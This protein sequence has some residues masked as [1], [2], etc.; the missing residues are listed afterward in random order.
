MTEADR[1]GLNVVSVK[2]FTDD[3][4]SDFTS[5]LNEIKAAGADLV[6]LPIYYSPASLILA[7][8]DR[9]R[10]EPKFFGVDGLDGIL[11]IENFDISL[12]EGVMLLTPF[13]ADSEDELTQSF[14]AKYREKYSETPNQ[15]A[16]DGYDAV[17]AIY[18][19]CLNKNITP[20]M[21]PQDICDALVE[22]FTNPEFKVD[23]LTGS[24]M[25]WSE[26]GEIS[27]SPKGMIIQNGVYVGM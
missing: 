27:K 26:T 14:V 13:T 4:A 19:A 25:T 2:S 15:F 8:A 16:A 21:S 1:I 22:E 17:I 11:T 12:A 6:F 18:Q 7:Q 5:Q 9:M 3:S 10:F 20:D 24:G 23:G